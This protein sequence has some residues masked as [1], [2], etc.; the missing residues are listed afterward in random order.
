MTSPYCRLLDLTLALLLA[1][2]ACAQKE[3]DVDGKPI[4]LRSP[5]EEFRQLHRSALSVGGRDEARRRLERFRRA[6]AQSKELDPAAQQVLAA[7]SLEPAPLAALEAFDE[8]GRPAIGVLYSLQLG[9][10]MAQPDRTRKR[11]LYELFGRISRHLEY[12]WFQA[13]SD[14]YLAEELAGGN[15]SSGGRV[16]PFVAPLLDAGPLDELARLFEEYGDRPWSTRALAWRVGAQQPEKLID[17]E[18]RETWRDLA[19]SE[20]PPAGDLDGLLF[21]AAGGRREELV[22]ARAASGAKA[23]QRPSEQT[24]ARIVE[25]FL[26]LRLPW[27]GYRYL[28]Q[29][30]ERWGTKHPQLVT[31]LEAAWQREFADRVPRLTMPWVVAGVR[32]VEGMTLGEFADQHERT[33]AGPGR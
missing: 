17:V 26:R 32:V 1:L 21:L 12:G 6:A 11:S 9:S 27:E 18:T 19:A 15:F 20:P 22:T 4:A 24:V 31:T 25:L 33:R 5:E 23:D 30:E 16:A 2:P 13:R 29:L 14:A 8:H 28:Q 3:G 10:A 7:L